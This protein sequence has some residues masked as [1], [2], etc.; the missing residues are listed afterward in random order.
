MNYDLFADNPKSK[1][2]KSTFRIFNKCDADW[3]DSKNGFT[4]ENGEEY[5]DGE[6]LN[7][8]QI[9]DNQREEYNLRCSNTDKFYDVDATRHPKGYWNAW[10]LYENSPISVEQ[11]SS[12]L[13]KKYISPPN[14][15]DIFNLPDIASISEKDLKEYLD[16]VVRAG[17]FAELYNSLSQ[18]GIEAVARYTYYRITLPDPLQ[19]YAEFNYDPVARLMLITMEVPDFVRLKVTTVL[20]TSKTTEVSA[21]EKAKQCEKLLY[22]LI[23]RAAYLVARSDTA[24]MFDTVAV[25]AGQQWFDAGSGK[26][27]DG[28]IASLQAQKEELVRL[29]LDNIDPKT[30]FRYLKGI[31]APSIENVSVIRPI[32]TLD[33]NDSRIVESRDVDYGLIPDTNLAA[34]PWED[35]E[36]LV[37]QLF[38][39]EFGRENIEI[40]V[41]QASRDRG[42]DAIMFDPDPIRGGKYVFQAK[43]YTRTVDVSA[44]RDLYGTVVNE[45][46]NRGVLV[47]TSGFGPDSYEFAK[48]KPISLVDGPSL[49]QLLKKHGRIY[50]IDLDEA[51][52]QLNEERDSYRINR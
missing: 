35:F 30:C 52:R 45:G 38:E 5:M 51:R 20:K 28:I 8:G 39:W 50:R 3:R 11:I 29:N 26:A 37:R 23:I 33:K 12:L 13:S 9:D 25:N 1:A 40:K 7:W 17:K 15:A 47:T 10:L 43:R 21:A 19:L 46:A 24:N 34:M 32:F 14:D 49:I 27:M 42:V 44:V 36:H 41:T 31:S 4:V 48:D 6:K 18:E 22:S 16:D 2:F